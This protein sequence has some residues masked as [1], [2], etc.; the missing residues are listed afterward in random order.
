MKLTRLQLAVATASLFDVVVE[1]PTAN[2]N[3]HLTPKGLIL[4]GKLTAAMATELVPALEAANVAPEDLTKTFYAEWSD[5]TERSRAEHFLN[6]VRHYMSTYGTG[7]RGEAVV[8]N[9]TFG[10]ADDTAKIYAIEAVPAKEIIDLAL[11]MLNSGIAL[12]TDTVKNLLNVLDTFNV[13]DEGITFKNQEAN[14]ILVAEYG[15]A[16]KDVVGLIRFMVSSVT[17]N[18]M[19]IKSDRVINALRDNPTAAAQRLKSFVNV[20]GIQE[21]AEN[22]NRY[23]PFLLAVKGCSGTTNLVNRIAKLSKKKHKPMEASPINL[24]TVDN[25]TGQDLSKVATPAILRALGAIQLRMLE[26]ETLRPVYRIRNG[27]LHVGEARPRAKLSMLLANRAYIMEELQKRVEGAGKKVYIPEGVDYALP[28]SEKSFVGGIPAYTTITRQ[29]ELSAGI[30]WHR[31]GG[32]SDLDLSAIDATGGKV[33]WNSSWRGGVAYSGDITSAPRGAV[34]FMRTLGVNTNQLLNVNIYHGDEG[35]KYKLIVGTPSDRDGMM[36]HKDLMFSADMQFTDRNDVLGT[37]SHAD[38]I[39]TFTV[40]NAGL[41]KAYVASG[42]EKVSAVLEYVN[43]VAQNRASLEDVLLE[44]GY[45]VTNNP[46]EEVDVS[47]APDLL[48]VETVL[49]LFL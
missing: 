11:R 17:D 37:L 6:Q 14:S 20:N 3:I 18:G 5:V 4:H 2:E 28:T 33:G 35:S 8:P 25:I 9:P 48:T 7:F 43:F 31:D 30:Y 46:D 32:A 49:G 15:H 16:P 39:S 36:K 45:E 42:T 34:E 38:G 1:Q 29:G 23:K 27:S 44:L 40:F 41:S 22:F 13:I 12:K 19:V 47:L 21:L 10:K 26:P 24:V